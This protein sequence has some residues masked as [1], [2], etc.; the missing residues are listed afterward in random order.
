MLFSESDQ[1]ILSIFQSVYN[2]CWFGQSWSVRKV[3]TE[4]NSLITTLSN[5]YNPILQLFLIS[6]TYASITSEVLR[7]DWA[8]VWSQSIINTSNSLWRIWA[9]DSH[10]DPKNCVLLTVRPITCFCSYGKIDFSSRNKSLLL[11][12][13]PLQSPKKLY[14]SYETLTRSAFYSLPNV[15]I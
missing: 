2:N 15:T 5:H 14:S 6:G 4:C 1:N 7:F 11:K 10:I 3:V 8:A 9:I 12:G 13:R